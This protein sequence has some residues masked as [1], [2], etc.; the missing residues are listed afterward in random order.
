[1][2]IGGGSI[3]CPVSLSGEILCRNGSYV[4]LWKQEMG[5]VLNRHVRNILL[6]LQVYIIGQIDVTHPQLKDLLLEGNQE[7]PL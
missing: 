5:N 6:D 7:L 2:S 4:G 1:M 3:V